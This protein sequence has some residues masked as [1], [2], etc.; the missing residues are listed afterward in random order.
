MYGIL[1]ASGITHCSSA[2]RLAC[3]SP[4]AVLLLLSSPGCRRCRLWLA[5]LLT[6]SCWAGWL[7]LAPFD[8]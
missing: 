6:P 8:Y 5:G 4:T 1:P 7:L 2:L 3:L